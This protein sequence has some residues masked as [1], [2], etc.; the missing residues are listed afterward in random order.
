[1]KNMNY[2]GFEK[3]AKGL[4]YYHKCEFCGLSQRTKKT[5]SIINHKFFSEIRRLESKRDTQSKL[6]DS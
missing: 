5:K 4:F 3:T 6:I 2:V 1:M